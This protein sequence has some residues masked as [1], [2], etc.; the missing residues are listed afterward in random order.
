MNQGGF[1]TGKK[2]QI[3]PYYIYRKYLI[4]LVS[5]VERLKQRIQI[6]GGRLILRLS[7]LMK[8]QKIL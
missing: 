7:L 5:S 3:N 6:I 1:K 8:N 2:Q 4:V